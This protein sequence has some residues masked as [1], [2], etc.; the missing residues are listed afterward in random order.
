[1]AILNRYLTTRIYTQDAALIR[2]VFVVSKSYEGDLPDNLELSDAVSS[3]TLNGTFLFSSAPAAPFDLEKS[4]LTKQ[5]DDVPSR[6]FIW[7][8]NCLLFYEDT[9]NKSFQKNLRGDIFFNIYAGAT[10]KFA[11]DTLSFS[12]SSLAFSNIQRGSFD[13][14]YIPL[15]GDFAGLFCF[16]YGVSVKDFEN[17]FPIGF[18]FGYS[19]KI[20]SITYPLASALSTKYDSVRFKVSMDFLGNASLFSFYSTDTVQPVFL[21]YYTTL[22]A[23]SVFLTPK[24]GAGLQFISSPYDDARSTLVPVG[25]YVIGSE[26]GSHKNGVLCGLNG[27]E[28]FIPPE[29]GFISFVNGF[30][31]FAP[32]YPKVAL[33]ISDFTDPAGNSPLI[34]DYTTAWAK[35]CKGTKYFS[36]PSKSPYYA[37]SGKDGLLLNAPLCREIEGCEIF[38]LV[39]ISTEGGVSYENSVIC[40]ARGAAFAKTPALYSSKNGVSSVASPTGYILKLDGGNVREIILS[41]EIAFANPSSE[42]VSAFNT[43]SLFLVCANQTAFSGNFGT[44][45]SG[46]NFSFS[47]GNES[48]YNDYKNIL[49]VKSAKGKIYDPDNA[50]ASLCGNVSLWTNAKTFSAP[51][52][53]TSQTANL[54]V[55]LQNYFTRQNDKDAFLS[56]IITDENWS[57]FI[58]VNVPILAENFPEELRTSVSESGATLDYFGAAHIPLKVENSQPV[59]SDTAKYFGF[60][61][62]QKDGYAGK[63]MPPTKSGEFEFTPLELKAVFRGNALVSFESAAQLVIIQFLGIKPQNLYGAV[64]MKGAYIKAEDGSYSY[65]LRTDSANTL[66]FKNLAL[67]KVLLKSVVLASSTNGNVFNISGEISFSKNEV[68]AWSY[69]SLSFSGYR[70]NQTGKVFSE[71]LLAL[72]LDIKNSVLRENSLFRAFGMSPSG[73]ITLEGEIKGYDKIIC[74]FLGGAGDGTRYAVTVP[75]NLGGAGELSGNTPITATLIF[76]FDEN[77]TFAVLSLPKTLNIE[78]VIN[79]TTGLAELKHDALTKRFSLYIYEVAL[80][81]FGL[82]KLPSTGAISLGM[83]GQDNDKPGWF[84]IYK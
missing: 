83:F 16:L 41:K 78:N 38:P 18:T 71:N 49:I 66:T 59:Q 75:V 34:D 80:N 50:G 54:A 68:D 7:G 3:K 77:G 14:A 12:P 31:A 57:G 24:E 47:I 17:A 48:K 29:D 28:Y 44:E 1:M 82:L 70:L 10:F 42:L 8:E 53:D 21:S 37:Y 6:A 15:T 46:F 69:D 84:A 13:N 74:D 36:E 32:K 40:T 19:D 45:I 65:Q 20:V 23:E 5:A 35:L 11:D 64:L 22:F 58:F 73:F 76:G 79:I 43:N 25:D 27:T 55:F 52:S 4:D 56:S 30:G 9:V 60:V 62:S 61:S 81:A 33:S 72:T 63:V 2:C 67:D 26:N 39:P 51:N